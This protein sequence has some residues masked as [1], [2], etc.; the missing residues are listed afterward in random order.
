METQPQRVRVCVF[1]RMRAYWQ[2]GW[3]SSQV[4]AGLDVQDGAFPGSRAGP[5]ASRMAWDLFVGPWLLTDGSQLL[6]WDDLR[7]STQGTAQTGTVS[8]LWPQR[9]R[10]HCCALWI[11]QAQT[12]GRERDP[13]ETRAAL[14]VCTAGGGGGAHPCG[15]DML[16]PHNPVH[17][18]S[19]THHNGKSE[20]TCS[21]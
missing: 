1:A 18:P 15:G 6:R 14:G 3:E 7:A 8:T 16:N 13:L 19:T 10:C 21:V 17:L 11:Q 4:S 9:S 20:T 2:L 5:S 12:R